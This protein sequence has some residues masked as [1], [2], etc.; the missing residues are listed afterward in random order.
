MALPKTWGNGKADPNAGQVLKNI[1][2]VYID[3][4]YCSFIGT[5][6]VNSLILK[7]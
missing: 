2:L 5:D 6:I 1:V 4:H 7:E 3:V